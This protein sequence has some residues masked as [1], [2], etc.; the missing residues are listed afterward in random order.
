MIDK[1]HES[2][3][4]ITEG[5]QDYLSNLAVDNVIFGYHGKELKVL[6]LKNPAISTW[7]LAGGY[8]KKTESAENAAARVA[9]ERT[10]L[11]NLFL[12]QFKV[13]STPGRN[14][15]PELTPEILS[16]LTGVKIDENHWMFSPIVSISF[17]TLTEF[18][19]VK[20]DTSYMGE[21]C[22]WWDVQTLPD[23][24]Q[25]HR[26]I[27]AEALK[28]LRLHIYHYPIGYELLPEKFTL[29]EIH[30]LYQ[31]ILGKQLDDRN[32]TRKLMSL[33][34]IIKLDEVKTSNHRP[35]NLYT[36]NKATYDQALEEGIFIF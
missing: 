32:F 22:K 28:A 34:I 33:G 12:Q 29:P 27:I 14:Q 8:I 20:V 3:R 21:E 15:T 36:F 1:S 6:L 30:N 16:D 17:Y 35:P 10:G 4:I 11:D 18:S 13:F 31:A 9:K 2:Y 23:L 25:D 19:K 5:N 26:Q 7:M 24:F